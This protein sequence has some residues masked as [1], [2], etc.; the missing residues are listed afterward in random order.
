MGSVVNVSLKEA[1]N[2]N[3]TPL[4]QT[5]RN[6]NKYA[7]VEFQDVE[8]VLFA[9]EMLDDILLFGKR[10]VVSPRDNTEQVNFQKIHFPNRIFFSVPKIQKS[11]KQISGVSTSA[12]LI[13]QFRCLVESSKRGQ[14]FS[15]EFGLSANIL[16]I[17]SR[18]YGRS[19]AYAAWK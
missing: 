5:P 1:R 17:S 9:V 18:K 6:N 15:R 16:E 2:N 19:V 8:S 7:F 14:I 3:Q 13:C 11:S 4:N 10:I 12:E